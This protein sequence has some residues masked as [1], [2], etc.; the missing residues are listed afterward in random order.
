M[1][2]FYFAHEAMLLVTCAALAVCSIGGAFRAKDLAL[3][4]API[5]FCA[6]LIL[7][8]RAY[9][10][11]VAGPKDFSL[12]PVVFFSTMHKLWGISGVLFGGFE[13][14]VRNL[15]MLLALTPVALAFATRLRRKEAEPPAMGQRIRRWRFELLALALFVAYLV[16]PAQLKSTALI[17]HRFLPPAWALIAVSA[18]AGVG[19][20]LRRLPRALC[21]APPLASL[22]VGWP[23]F[24]D[25]HGIYSELEPLL[26]RIEIGST[27]VVLGVGPHEHRLWS[28]VV[29]SG[30]VVALR[31][32]K[33]VFDFTQSPVSP[34]VQRPTK[35]W[36]KTAAR[37]D[38]YPLNFRPASDLTRFRY[39]LVL[40]T[41][42]GYAAVMAVAL[43]NQAKLI[44]QN[45]RW[46]LFESQ[47]PLVPIDSDEAP[48]PRPLPPT[49]RDRFR[50]IAQQGIDQG[51][52]LAAPT[53]EATP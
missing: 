4:V 18:G 42:Q 32:G 2:L 51:D 49:V 3:R 8:G 36:V 34:V 20:A 1:L 5:A 27:Y 14:Y 39:V 37:M 15:M 16:A 46:Y 48:L 33:S 21:V 9:D 6:G 44:A 19:S 25:S 41:N 23:S 31:G 52:T 7:A 30:H 17:Y 28:P 50:E 35:R 43:G 29:V 10:W 45:G 22:L 47:L 12:P 53:R 26:D 11:R 24:A 38:G 40:A 13:P